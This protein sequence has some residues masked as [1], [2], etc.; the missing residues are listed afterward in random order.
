MIIEFPTH[1]KHSRQ[2]PTIRQM[3]E[4]IFRLEDEINRILEEF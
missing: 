3:D 2:Q 1:I 4:K